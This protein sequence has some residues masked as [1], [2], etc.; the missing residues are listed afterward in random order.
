MYTYAQNVQPLNDN[1]KLVQHFEMTH[2]I[3][4]NRVHDSKFLLQ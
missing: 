1:E 3:F 2:C 4:P